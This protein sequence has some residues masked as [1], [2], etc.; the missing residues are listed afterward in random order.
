MLAD[1]VERGLEEIG[2]VHAGNFDRILEREKHPFARAFLGIEVEQI[3]AVVKHFAAGDVIAVAAG[4]HRGERALAAA[5]RP[6][7]RM[8]FAG[9]DGE[10]DAFENLFALHTGA[11]VFDFEN[12][13]LLIG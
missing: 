7:D 13:L 4:E 12:G 9:I 8:D 5:I 10:V 6:H 3:L 2:A 1:F 11:E